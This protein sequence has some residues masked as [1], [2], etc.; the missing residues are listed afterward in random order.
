[1]ES[2]IVCID[3]E[4]YRTA[5]MEWKEQWKESQTRNYFVSADFD[6][7]IGLNYSW[8]NNDTKTYKFRI[9]DKQKWLIAKI[10]YGI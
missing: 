10:K 7:T 2:D 5:C 9:F 4:K 1:M 8:F 3:E 6:Q